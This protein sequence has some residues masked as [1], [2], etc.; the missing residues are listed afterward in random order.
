MR[1]S[2]EVVSVSLTLISV[3]GR[4]AEGPGDGKAEERELWRAG[5][6]G[7]SWGP[8]GWEEGCVGIASERVGRRVCPCRCMSLCAE[9]NNIQGGS[10]ILPGPGWYI[11]RPSSLVGPR[12]AWRVPCPALPDHVFR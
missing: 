6:D 11:K 7:L 4:A 12:V 9:S 2:R 8:R 10:H 1:D 3:G 5:T